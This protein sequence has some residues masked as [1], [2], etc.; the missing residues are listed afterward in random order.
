MMKNVVSLSHRCV[1][2]MHTSRSVSAST[3]SRAARARARAA[4]RRRRSAGA[5]AGTSPARWTAA[6]AGS[7]SP[8]ARETARWTRSSRLRNCRPTVSLICR[9]AERIHT[10]RALF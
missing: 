3:W 9:T 5:A 7:R 8:C 1:H 4:A 10:L 6:A 2:T